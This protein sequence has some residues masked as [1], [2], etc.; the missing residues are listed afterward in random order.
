MVRAQLFAT[1]PPYPFFPFPHVHVF[2]PVCPYVHPSMTR[3]WF[4][5]VFHGARPVCCNTA[6]YPFFPF[7]HVH[8]FWPVCLY[9]HPS[10]P[11]TRFSPVFHDA[12]P[13]F[14]KTAVIPRVSPFPQVHVFWPV[15]PYVHPSMPRTWFSPVFHGARPVFC[16]TAVV[17][18]FLAF[19]FFRPCART[20]IRPF[21]A[22]CFPLFSM[23]RA[24]LFATRPPYPFFGAPRVIVRGF[25]GAPR[26][27][28]VCLS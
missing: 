1:R 15:C 19:T 4:A 5:P 18:R 8:V 11:R 27:V 21:H 24:Q 3:T 9:V 17:P 12:R 7:P 22:H 16:N 23:V 2:W 10:M 26:M 6:P 20:C 28:I 14:C 25:V 13:V